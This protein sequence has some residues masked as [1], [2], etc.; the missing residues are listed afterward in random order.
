M[1]H[2]TLVLRTGTKSSTRAVGTLIQRVI[3]KSESFL[4]ETDSGVMVLWDPEAEDSHIYHSQIG[5]AREPLV[6][7]E[8]NSEKPRVTVGTLI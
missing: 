8:S 3:S 4:C 2:L 7:I 1:S 5:N 6:W